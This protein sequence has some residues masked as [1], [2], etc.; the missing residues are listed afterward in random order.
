MKVKAFCWGLLIALA[1]VAQA[2]RVVELYIDNVPLDVVLLEEA[3][4]RLLLPINLVPVEMVS[5]Q[6]LKNLDRANHPTCSDCIYVDQ[7][8]SYREEAESGKAY[9]SIFPRFRGVRAVDIGARRNL[10]LSAVQRRPGLIASFFAT[11]L[12]T[13]LNEGESYSLATLGSLSLGPLGVIQGGER[14]NRVGDITESTRLPLKWLYHDIRHAV[15]F[16]AGEFAASSDPNEGA[17][18]VTGLRLYK[19]FTLRPDIFD[20]PV[21]DF[22]TELERPST[23]ELYLNSRQIYRQQFGQ[24][25]PVRLEN[26][27]PSSTGKVLLVV[28]DSLGA[29][30][31]LETDLYV[32]SRLLDDGVSDYEFSVGWLRESNDKVFWD[33]HLFTG[34]YSLGITDSFTAGISVSAANHLENLDNF[35]E[36]RSESYN[37]GVNALWGS[38]LGRLEGAIRYSDSALE[39]EDG[40]SGRL[41]WSYNWLRHRFAVGVGLT[42]FYEHNYRPLL[43]EEFRD[44]RGGRA[45]LGL[46]VGRFVFGGNYFQFRDDRFR[47]NLIFDGVEEGGGLNMSY[48]FGPLQAQV[49][50]QTATGTPDLWMASATYHF[51]SGPLRLA[52]ARFNRESSTGVQR[53]ALDLAG[54]SLEHSLNWRLQAEEHRD[55]LRAEDSRSYNASLGWDGDHADISY[56]GSRFS[57]E[58]EH[59]VDMSTALMLSGGGDIGVW[60]AANSNSSFVVVDAGI[61]DVEVA[62]GGFE[63][64]TGWRGR[65]LLPASAM[66]GQ[67]VDVARDTLPLG[68]LPEFNR[69]A[70]YVAPS[71]GAY[72]PVRFLAPKA[73]LKVAGAKVGDLVLVNGKSFAVYDFGVFADNLEV[74]NNVIE[75][76]GQKKMLRIE[77]VDQS[78]PTYYLK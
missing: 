2:A 44:I 38:S 48:R 68:Y 55:D 13:S 12:D 52:G 69:S 64:K 62:A 26:Y 78:L 3:D 51:D 57:G 28:R 35:P 22:F 43:A 11:A 20:R 61:P 46:A 4:G 34:R 21:Y 7:L 31:V 5:E 42:G 54:G 37:G 58:Q 41:S 9:I 27:R 30:R 73:F 65:V 19:N 66:T 6:S 72:V 60:S 16:E 59:L 29:Q 10:D 49:S 56:R 18:A 67:F 74:G 8:G 39:K 40:Y 50:W 75:F 36:D 45:F 24:A 70:V 25:G 23:I 77:N 53:A 76:A 14:L 32:D 71:Q 17:V 1:P 63:G 33:S 15:T 47:D